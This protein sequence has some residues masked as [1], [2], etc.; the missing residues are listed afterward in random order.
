MSNT[1]H[2]YR[3]DGVPCGHCPQPAELLAAY[4]GYTVTIHPGG[5]ACMSIDPL[6]EAP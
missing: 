6:R 1:K 5:K 4:L 2:V 3:I